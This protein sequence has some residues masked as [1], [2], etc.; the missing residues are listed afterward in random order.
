MSVKTVAS[1]GSWRSPIT[2]E[3]VAR[4]A[5]IIRQL[6]VAQDG[7]YWTELRPWEGGRTLIVHLD[8]QGNLRDVT[9]P[10]FNVR[11]RVHEYGRSS[12]APKYPAGT[13]V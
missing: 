12:R 2:A 1:F 5:P 11:S 7:I 13:M 10:G 8:G 9:P 4:A 6:Q 3:K